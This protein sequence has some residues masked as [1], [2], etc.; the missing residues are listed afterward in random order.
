MILEPGDVLVIPH[1]WWH[2]VESLEN[3]ISINSWIELVSELLNYLSAAVLYSLTE[4]GVKTNVF[5]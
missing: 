4:T 3:S 2:F 1:L 5:Y